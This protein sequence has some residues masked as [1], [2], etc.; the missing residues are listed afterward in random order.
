MIFE[1]KSLCVIVLLDP[2]KGVRYIELVHNEDSDD[3]LDC[4]YQ[5]TAHDQDWVNPTPDER[6][7]WE[8]DSSCTSDSDEEIE[9]WQDRFHEVTMLNCNMMVR[10]L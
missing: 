8:C 3:E 5:I 10:S 6:I 7:S 4:I 2:A 9:K 1:K